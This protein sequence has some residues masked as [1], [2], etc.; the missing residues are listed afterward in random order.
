[1]YIKY[2]KKS[3]FIK[4]CSTVQGKSLRFKNKAQNKGILK[5][6]NL[7]K[8]IRECLIK[9]FTFCYNSIYTVY[10]DAKYSAG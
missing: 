3:H 7:I 5:D 2:G 4:K 6:D 10:K 9:Y 8:S 1:V